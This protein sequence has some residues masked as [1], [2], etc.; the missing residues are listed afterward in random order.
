MCVPTNKDFE[1][2]HINE[3]KRIIIPLFMFQMYKKLQ[4]SLM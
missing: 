4:T 3:L 1:N 2:K